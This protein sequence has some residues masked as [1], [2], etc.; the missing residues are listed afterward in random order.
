MERA[1]QRGGTVIGRWRQK[2]KFT[3]RA[4][5]IDVLVLSSG[6]ET[7]LT[8]TL[9][10]I[11]ASSLS[12]NSTTVIA[13]PKHRMSSNDSSVSDPSERDDFFTV[14]S[15][16]PEAINELRGDYFLFLKAGACLTPD[17]PQRLLETLS[18][19]RVH[20]LN[21]D[22]V[23]ADSRLG[24]P[25]P[26]NVFSLLTAIYE[27]WGVLCS[28]AL[29]R[30]VGEL[31]AELLSIQW[32]DFFLRLYEQ[33]GNVLATTKDVLIE[34]D[35]PDYHLG[36]IESYYRWCSSSTPEIT[37]ELPGRQAEEQGFYHSL[38]AE[39]CERHRELMDSLVGFF[40]PEL[41]SKNRVIPE[42]R[43]SIEDMKA[44]C[45]NVERAYHKSQDR[46]REA[47]N[48]YKRAKDKRQ[49]ALSAYQALKARYQSLEA[50]ADELRSQVGELE[51]QM[52]MTKSKRL[53]FSR[54]ISTLEARKQSLEAKNSKLARQ[55]RE[56]RL[57]KEPWS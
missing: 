16:L 32:L 50:E 48:S 54:E 7:A 35:A 26:D 39:L 53:E 12:F 49:E 46:R 17:A 34:V 45:K 56:G 33:R 57:A 21:L 2:K 28:R 31:E 19:G 43:R 10:S 11:V 14:F 18:P 25:P 52:L 38:L 1:S 51:A 13:P 37:D 40:V 30:E 20:C 6:D 24:V 55:L 47:E 3:E 29:Y 4:Q 36:V 8:K 9:A 44:Q 42:L 5:Q 23:S 27:P 15:R 41:L 22:V